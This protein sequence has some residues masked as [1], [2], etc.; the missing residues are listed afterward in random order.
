MNKAVQEYSKGNN[1]QV[2]TTEFIEA[3]KQ[4]VQYDDIIKDTNN[5]LKIYRKKKT[6]LG[7]SIQNYMKK[8][9]IENNDINITGGGKLRYKTT[10]K[11]IPVN[12]EYI[13]KRLVEY[14]GGNTEKAEKLVDFI[15][16]D[17]EKVMGS[18]LSRTRPK[19]ITNSSNE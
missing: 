2:I 12:R 3:I 14:F 1:G 4:W 9:N 8:N 17:R 15:Y 16:E 11:L 13:Y 6:E 19:K 7:T 10:A 18:I 5:K